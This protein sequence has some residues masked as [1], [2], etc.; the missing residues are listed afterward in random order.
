MS[1]RTVSHT[2]YTDDGEEEVLE[3]PAKFE[4][5]W[6]CRG[7]GSHV[8]PAIDGHGL[9]QEDFDEDPDFR[10]NYFSGVYDVPCYECKGYRVT[11]VMD[12]SRF[13][14]EHKASMVLL[15]KQ[16]EWEARDRAEA[17]MERRMGA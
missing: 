8:N 2:L 11:L 15:E 1:D 17:E 5:C 10:E 6:R 12:E 3:F 13:T 14:E 7:E 4:V 9:S 16:W